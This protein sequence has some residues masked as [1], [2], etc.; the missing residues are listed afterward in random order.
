MMPLRYSL[1]G[2]RGRQL[3]HEENCTGLAGHE[4]L[5]TVFS[6]EQKGESVVAIFP[7]KPSKTLFLQM[8][9]EL[10][11]PSYQIQDAIH[12]AFLFYDSVNFA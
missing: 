3:H 1:S 4:M 10:M 12:G 6:R 2:Q 11:C 7:L 8:E 9:V 5:T